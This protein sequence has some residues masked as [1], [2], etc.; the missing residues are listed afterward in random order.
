MNIDELKN[1]IIEASNNELM[2]RFQRCQTEVKAD[3]SLVTEADF[4]VQ[5]AIQNALKT[6]WPEYAF[7]AEEMSADEMNAFFDAN[8]DGFWCLD[9]LD[10]TSNFSSGIPYFAISLAFIQQG[11]VQLGIVYDPNRD[12]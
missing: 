2:P 10:G 7:L 8:P 6:R 3:G 12:E 9:P 1:I 5:S 11:E 4:A